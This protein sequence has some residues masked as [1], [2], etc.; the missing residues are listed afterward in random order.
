LPIPASLRVELGIESAAGVAGGCIHDCYRV[1]I[2]GTVRFLKT[3]SAEYE[4]AFAAEA[5]GLAALRT[6]GMRA[7]EPHS[8]GV[9]AGRAYLVLEYLDLAGKK[10]F[11]ALGRMLAAA[12]R[13][14][15]PRFGWHRDN[16]IGATPQANGWCDDWQEFWIE[17]RLRPQIELARRNGFPLTAPSVKV[18]EGHRPVASLLHGDLWGGNAGF[19]AEGPVVFDPAAYY[20]DREADLAM[21][22]LFG[23]FP[24][25]FYEAYEEAWPL[26]VG[27]EQRKPMYDL[28]HLLNHLNLFGGSYLGQVKSTLQLLH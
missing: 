6:G 10:D 9:A 11:A 15:G 28:Y 18:L 2:A 27:Y 25:E 1:S 20:G 17:R 21:T 16:Y 12:H 23:G 3:N 19:T 13:K 5:D 4:D 24:R 14:A 8:H 26:D 22:E 7:P